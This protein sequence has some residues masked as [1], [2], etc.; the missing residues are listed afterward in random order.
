MTGPK[1]TLTDELRSVLLSHS[2]D[3]PEPDETVDWILA[4][5]V[6]AEPESVGPRWLQWRPSGQAWVAAAVVALLVLAGAGVNELRK[7]NG[8]SSG[9][10]TAASVA[11]PT[12]ARANTGSSAAASSAA[13]GV[14]PN[15]LAEPDSSASGDASKLP[16]Q[17]TRTG[18][19]SGTPPLNGTGLNCATIP[20]GHLVSGSTVSYQV[21]S[22]TR[23]A[24][25]YSCVGTNGARS[26]SEVQT[27]ERVDG[28]LRYV[29]T[30]LGSTDGYQVSDLTDAPT[31]FD[32]NAI[33][34]AGPRLGSIVTL[35]V[36]SAPNKS[37]VLTPDV[38]ATACRP[39][40][41]TAEVD[42]GM[43]SI[44]NSKVVPTTYSVVAV[45]NK[46]TMPCALSGYPTLAVAGATPSG[47]VV[48]HTL[49]G[50]NGG[51]TEA[52]VVP[53]INLEPGGV[54]SAVIETPVASARC[55][56]A[57]F[58][59]AL[60]NGEPLIAKTGLPLCDVTVH[61]FVDNQSGSDTG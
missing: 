53:I 28:T 22:G 8:A 26:T 25:E 24:Y 39:G 50:P 46:T 40:D 34:V 7:N 48:P 13:R 59:V 37:E 15:D 57:P 23:Y 17:D 5:T 52:R 2:M 49:S 29:D 35:H 3:A 36:F 60:P 47:S 54:A 9:S 56:M 11:G 18:S 14:A 58:S 12:S 16:L 44:V 43:D 27:F 6:E 55:S 21:G 33:A 31:G 20:G 4:Q 30:A 19:P 32:I 42:S 61:P 51:V 45:K 41:L 1:K 10:S 38:Q